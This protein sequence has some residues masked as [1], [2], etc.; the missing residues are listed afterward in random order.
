MTWQEVFSRPHL[1]GPD[2]LLEV[3][4]VQAQARLQPQRVAR[5]QAVPQGPVRTYVTL[6]GLT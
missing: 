5:A 6:A 1:D 3:V 2:V 4:A